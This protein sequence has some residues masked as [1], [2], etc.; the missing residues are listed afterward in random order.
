MKKRTKMKTGFALMGIAFMVLVTVAPA[1]AQSPIV[2]KIGNPGP[3]DPHKHMIAAATL[4]FK[5]YVERNS[6][7]GIKV[8][9]YPGFQLG[10]MPQMVD[11]TKMGAIQATTVFSAAA[12]LYV[13]EIDLIYAPFVFS[14]PEIAWRVFDGPFGQKFNELWLKAGFVP[15]YMADNGGSRAFGTTT[16]QIKGPDDLKGLKIRI[17]ESEAL[18]IFMES[19]GAA[20]PVITFSQ[21]YTSLQ[22]G[23]VDGLECP[24]AVL[25]FASLD[26]VIK[27]ASVTSHTWDMVFL[28]V[29]KDWYKKLPKDY[30]EIL[31]EAGRHAEQVCKGMSETLAAELVANLLSKGVKVYTPTQKER[32]EFKKVTQK[33]VIDFLKKKLGQDIVNEFLSAVEK[34]DMEAQKDTERYRS[35]VGERI[36]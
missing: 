27:Y 15:L 4:V 20:A 3:G 2:M 1:L 17:P 13:P 30:Q 22:T 33:P 35:F 32:D 10:T 9:V 26:E 36:K 11:M 6:Q 23:I 14:S 29:N 31:I 24:L 28:I 21:V 8:E 18:K 7:G 19:C 16:R 25:S 5:D 34:A 12:T